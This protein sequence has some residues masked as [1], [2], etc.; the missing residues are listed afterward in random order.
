VAEGVVDRREAVD[1]AEQDGGAAARLG[2]S[3]LEDALERVTPATA[4]PATRTLSLT[5]SISSTSSGWLTSR[6][7]RPTSST[8]ERPSSRQ[9]AGFTRTMRRRAS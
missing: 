3:R 8:A 1:V 6:T 4:S 7:D 2:Q 5:R 9:K